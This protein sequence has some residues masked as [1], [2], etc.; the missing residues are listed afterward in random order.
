M[1]DAGRS[2]QDLKPFAVGG[3]DDAEVAAV[4]GG[5]G[6][7]TE[8]F[9]SRNHRGVDSAKRHIAVGVNQFGD[10][11]PITRCHRL[12]NQVSGS[13]IAQEPHLGPWT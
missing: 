10:A 3:P 13:E 5:H 1:T 2:G 12:R 8:S 9:G 11:Q 7:R 4:D 6:V